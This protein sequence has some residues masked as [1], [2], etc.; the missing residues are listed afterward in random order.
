[1]HKHNETKTLIWQ[2][3]LYSLIYEKLNICCVVFSKLTVYNCFALNP[4]FKSHL[5]SVRHA[6]KHKAICTLILKHMLLKTAGFGY[7]NVR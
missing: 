7:H 1:M 5:C 4:H 3:F 2:S 6:F